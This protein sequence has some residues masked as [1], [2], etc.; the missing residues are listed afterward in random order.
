[1]SC[2][3]RP[4]LGLGF[5]TRG[6]DHKSCDVEQLVSFIGSCNIMYLKKPRKTLWI[7]WIQYD[8]SFSYKTLVI[9]WLRGTLH[10]YDIHPTY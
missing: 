1:M 10:K 9:T 4:V 7:I 5:R 3:H 6:S 2:H 8:V